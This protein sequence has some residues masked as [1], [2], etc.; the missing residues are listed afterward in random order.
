[1][2]AIMRTACLPS[3][4]LLKHVQ[5]APSQFNEVLHEKFFRGIKIPGKN[6]KCL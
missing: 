6:D 1:M 5:H 3:S 4:A 2:R